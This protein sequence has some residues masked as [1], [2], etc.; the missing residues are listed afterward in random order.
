MNKPNNYD[1]VQA[2]SPINQGPKAGPYILGIVNAELKI[3]KS[4]NEMLV[5]SVDIAEGEHR[6]YF[7]KLSKKL[8]KDCSLKYYQLTEGNSTKYF[9]GTITSIEHSNNGYAFNFDEKTLTGKLVGGNL[10]E[11]EYY[12]NNGEIKSNLKIAYMFNKNK[13]DEQKV[14]SPKK[15][16]PNL[17]GNDFNM[18]DIN[19]TGL[20][21]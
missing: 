12:A 14:L 13:I 15:I 21:F 4:G 18:P 1:N 19:D 10:R 3:S 20:P 6:G 9:K 8:D 17:N 2:A 5:L 7:N 16:D 11:E